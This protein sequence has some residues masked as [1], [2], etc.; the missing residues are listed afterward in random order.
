MK[1]IITLLAVALTATLSFGQTVV[2]Q[3][4]LSSWSAGDPT[5]F[6]GP[7]NS[8]S[9]DSVT[10]VSIG[11]MHGT[12]FANVKNAASGH[13]R[14][15]TQ[16][17]AVAPNEKYV[18]SMYVA[19]TA[20]DLRVRCYDVSNLA[21]VGG[22]T[23]YQTIS[24]GALTVYTDTITTPAT[25]YSMSYILSMRN[26]P[27]LGIGID[28]IVI[29]GAAP[30]APPALSY[31]VKTIRD[32]QFTTDFSGDS[33]LIDTLVETT[34]IVTGTG[35]TGY[36]IQTSSAAWEGVYVVDGT[37]TPNRGDE[38]TVQ[39]KV[40]EG[41]SNTEII[42]IDT[43][44]VN[45]TGN[46]VPTPIAVTTDSAV[47]EKYEGVLV[48]VSAAICTDT[49]QSFGEWFITNP[50]L[51]RL[52]V[53]D[54]LLSTPY[55]PVL[56]QGYDVTGIMY[57]S[58]GNF[59]IEPRDSTDIVQSLLVSVEENS[60][61]LNLM[62]YPNPVDEM[63]TISGVNL[64]RADIYTATGKLVKSVSLNTVNTIDVSELSNGVYVVRVISGKNV[65]V[66]RFVKQ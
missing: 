35:N 8:I 38:I 22:Y 43:M 63:F 47:L 40:R 50:T 13:R 42:A 23:S 41:F 29:T 19:G 6:F 11:A 39:G 30:V 28:S 53:D 26:L 21:Y 24:G 65:G 62:V 58:F 60:N 9:S 36:F 33:P 48:K 2:F 14:L 18:I 5:D 61:E 32:I 45:S 49:V 16:A 37:N 7:V 25:C 52:M 46:V 4:D 20:G 55:N 44:I 3:S 10:E 12:S 31:S 1:R 66:S 34:G 51:N 54:L 59:K 57:Y 17:F 56:N 64:E 27:I 15:T